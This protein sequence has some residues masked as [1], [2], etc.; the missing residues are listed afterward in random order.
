[1]DVGGISSGSV[2]EL[3]SSTSVVLGIGCVVGGTDEEVL[4]ISGTVV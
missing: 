1:M 3:S 4:T 2:V